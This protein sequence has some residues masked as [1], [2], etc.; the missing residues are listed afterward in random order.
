MPM[1]GFD[2]KD[3]PGGYNDVI[4]LGC[5]ILK[6]KG[7][8]IENVKFSRIEVLLQQFSDRSFAN[9]LS[10]NCSTS[11]ATSRKANANCA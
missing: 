10:S 3:T 6:R 1:L 11:D 4:N 5:S 7:D 9:V 8:I 2:D